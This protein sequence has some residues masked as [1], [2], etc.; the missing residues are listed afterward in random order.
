MQSS[1]AGSYA[2]LGYAALGREVRTL[3]LCLLTLDLSGSRVPLITLFHELEQP[4][5]CLSRVNFEVLLKCCLLN[6]H[7][8]KKYFQVAYTNSS[9]VIVIVN[10]WT[11]ERLPLNSEPVAA[12]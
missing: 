10:F 8:I 9:Y 5:T 7:T 4:Q 1:Y 3:I 11:R 6:T 12:Y 2:A